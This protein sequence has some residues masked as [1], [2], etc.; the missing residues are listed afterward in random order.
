MITFNRSTLQAAALHYIGNDLADEALQLSAESFVPDPDT[1]ALLWQHIEKAFSEPD[2]QKFTGDSPVWP[3]A[4]TFFEKPES[5][6]LETSRHLAETLHRR[7]QKPSIKSGELLVLHLR[8]VVYQEQ[9]TD[10]LVLFKTDVKHPFL[11]TDLQ[12]DRLSLHSY[13]GISPGKIDK[14]ALIINCEAGDGYHILAQDQ[15]GSGNV[16]LFW[17]EE[18]LGLSPRPT[19][20]H[21]TAQFLEATRDFINSNLGD[22]ETELERM[23]KIALLQKSAD[24]VEEHD[25]VDS[26]EF[27]LQ[28][29]E[30]PAV[31]DRFRAYTAQPEA[32]EEA[33]QNFDLSTEAVKK[34]RGLFKSILKLDKNFHVY[35]HGNRQ[36]IEQGQEADGRKFYKLYYQEE[37]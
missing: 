7:S 18:F 8:N 36:M 23:D 29:F 3:L 10:A 37:S 21:H 28:V 22:E 6:F 24:F 32:G 31:A 5:A 11:F 27:G 35:I 13:R 16:A 14:A 2:F 33:P 30:D 26:Q 4:N 9:P 25:T 20:Y 17:K 15:R 1:E 19:A 12:E 34:H